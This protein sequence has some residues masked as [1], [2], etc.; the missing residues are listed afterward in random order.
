VLRFLGRNIIFVTFPLVMLAIAFFAR[1]SFQT[2]RNFGLW[3]EQ[4]IVNSTFLLAKEKVER[5]ENRISST[6]H[7]FFQ[8]IDPSLQETSCERWQAAIAYTGMVEA[9]A[10]VNEDGDVLQFYHRN[11]AFSQDREIFNLLNTEIIPLIDPWESFYQHKHLHKLFGGDYRM[12]STYTVEDGN[13]LVTAIL[14]YDTADIINVLF[15][16]LLE[17]MGDDHV[18]NVTDHTGQLIWGEQ[19]RGA[20]DFIVV[21]RFP[22][23][24]YKWQ[25]QLAPTSAA[26]FEKN[27]DA[28]KI[29][30]WILI[31]LSFG[32]IVFSLL[33][34][35]MVWVRERR[36]NR[37]KSEFIANASHELK[38]PL[39]LIRMFSEL[40]AMRKVDD[41]EK[42]QQYHQIIQRETDRLT[43][44]IDNVLDFAKLERGK[45]VYEFKEVH[46]EDTIA[47][48]LDIYRHRVTEIKASL[49]FKAQENL[50]V[51]RADANAV[52]LA[53]LNLIDNAIKY[54]QG[55]DVIGVELY[56]RSGRLHLDV[57]DRGQGIPPHHI[58]RVFERFYR[59]QAPDLNTRGQRGSGIGLSLVKHIARAHGGHVTVTSTPGVE[60]RFSIR[61]PIPP[62]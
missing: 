40:L 27:A 49:N 62:R 60:T 38:T 17:N 3:G 23:T 34:L 28:A 46:I 1:T 35:Y 21:Q 45:S 37:L 32:I 22:N 2:A 31:P 48:A 19:L 44:L 9:A 15:N 42:I 18:I 5:L 8:I 61:F 47:T 30:D 55:T 52:T 33:V 36:L 53:L 58:K 24:L 56:T 26:S 20:S 11:P 39:A 6:D 51:I 14:I 12:I 13:N 50:P 57:Y 59:F 43:A 10:I 41:P 54:A 16:T 29:S 7:T 4:S 25:I